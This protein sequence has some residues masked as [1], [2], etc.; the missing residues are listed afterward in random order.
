MANFAN[1]IH[2]S[3]LFVQFGRHR[4][5]LHGR[6]VHTALSPY[7]PRLKI[8][9]VSPTVQPDE[10][11]LSAQPL[12]TAKVDVETEAPQ[13]EDLP[14]VPAVAVKVFGLDLRPSEFPIRKATPVK[15]R[16]Q[17]LSIS[18]RRTRTPPPSKPSQ[19][20][21]KDTDTPPK[22]THFCPSI[23]RDS[24][25]L[26]CGYVRYSTPR[27]KDR[28]KSPR[29]VDPAPLPIDFLVVTACKAARVCC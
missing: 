13:L 22:G 25:R 11:E 4:S 17:R 16:P 24:P 8:S 9:I 5:H 2:S 20:L 15:K 1:R 3:P 21:C 12:P 26:R 19:S 29:R 18:S 23:V 28:S 6:P 14:R 27:S 10:V 7:R